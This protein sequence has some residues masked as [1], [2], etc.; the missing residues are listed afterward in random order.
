MG[1][2][3]AKATQRSWTC[4]KGGQSRWR[5]LGA[6]ADQNVLNSSAPGDDQANGAPNFVGKLR[7]SFCRFSRKDFI[8]GHTPAVEPLKHCELAGAE[9]E[10]LSVNFWNGRRFLIGVG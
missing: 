8:Y 9:T 4:A 6:G 5:W 1:A 7:E 3:E 2:Y 10:N